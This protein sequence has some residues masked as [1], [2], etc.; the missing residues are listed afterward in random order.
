MEKAI[1]SN[2]R[3]IDFTWA[4]FTE[5]FEAQ[6]GHLFKIHSNCPIPRKESQEFIN[7]TECATLTGYKPDYIRQL[8]FRKKIPFYKNPNRK[9]I[10]F[11]RDEVLQWMATK[12]FVPIDELADNYFG[13]S[14][15]IAI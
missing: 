14:K 1:S 9:P 4:E 8:V 7:I 10:R 2:K 15:N 12:K 5:A 11:Q 13:R 6:Y 3:I